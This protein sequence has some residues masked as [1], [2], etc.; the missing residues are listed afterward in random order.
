M[1]FL[2][3]G[4]AGFIGHRIALTLLE[5]GHQ[6]SGIDNLNAYYDVALKEARLERLK[7]FP[8]FRFGPLD[9]AD[10]EQLLALPQ[11]GEIDR[12]IHLAAQAGVRHSLK[13]PFSYA[14]ANLTG[15][16]SV[17]EF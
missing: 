5:A 14:S 9:I 17:L 7:P 6:V 1:H 3:T 12:V 13:A 10:H 16:L 2:V 4:V 8:A 11:R 15:H